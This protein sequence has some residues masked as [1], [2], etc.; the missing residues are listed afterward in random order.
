[1]NTANIFISHSWA[2][3]DAYEKLIKLLEGRHYFAFKDYS[4]PS[5]DPLDTSKDKELESAITNQMRPCCCVLI[6]AGVYATYSKWINKEIAIAKKGFSSPKPI[7]AIQPWAAEKTSA[8]V[9]DVADL[10][11]GWN[12]ESIVKAIRSFC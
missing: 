5:S 12:T 4:V 11:V 2:Y 6:L 9:K 1:M 7:I 3:S 8:T 10:I